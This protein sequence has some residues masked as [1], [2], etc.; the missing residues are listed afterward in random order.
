[1]SD[2]TQ[3]L[4]VDMIVRASADVSYRYVFAAFSYESR[5]GRYFFDLVPTKQGFNIEGGILASSVVSFL[6]FHTAETPDL[7]IGETVET[8]SEQ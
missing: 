8:P 4:T 5:D 1:M 6:T 7:T 2:Q 3:T